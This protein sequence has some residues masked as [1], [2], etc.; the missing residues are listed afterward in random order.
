MPEENDHSFDR[1]TIFQL[2]HRQFQRSPRRL[3]RVIDVRIRARRQES[4]ELGQVVLI[5][6]LEYVVWRGNSEKRWYIRVLT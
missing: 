5:N 2:T 1:P 3:V 6:G 4:G